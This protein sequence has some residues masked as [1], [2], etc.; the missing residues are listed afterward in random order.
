MEPSVPSTPSLSLSPFWGEDKGRLK[1]YCFL[2]G[3]KP[4]EE[5]YED[6][7]QFGSDLSPAID[8]TDSLR[9]KSVYEKWVQQNSSR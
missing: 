3:I 4:L 6:K 7:E 1:M 5:F 2:I 8:I 9:M